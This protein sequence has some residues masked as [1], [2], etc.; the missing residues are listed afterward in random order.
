MNI[1]IYV[2]IE[3]E[4]S[5]YMYIL[6][7]VEILSYINCCG[8]FIIYVYIL[9]AVELSLYIYILIAVEIVLYISSVQRASPNC[10]SYIVL[11]PLHKIRLIYSSCL[12]QLKVRAEDGGT[13]P[14]SSTAT[15]SITVNRNLN[16]PEF[17]PDR[18][19][20]EIL[21]TQPLGDPIV[22]VTANDK[23]NVVCVPL[24]FHIHKNIFGY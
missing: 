19:E 3:L 17:R 11:L 9:I 7:A 14:L 24:F 15:V 5:L 23:D 13:P 21:E 4:I 20:A 12:Y 10:Y 6:I 2:L 8:T 22:M 1:S 18:Y 16:V